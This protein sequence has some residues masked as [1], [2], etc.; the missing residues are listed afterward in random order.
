MSGKK[1]EFMKYSFRQNLYDNFLGYIF[2]ADI[3]GTLYQVSS[4]CGGILISP[5]HVLTA[6]HCTRHLEEYIGNFDTSLYSAYGDKNNQQVT[7]HMYIA[8]NFSLCRSM[9]KVKLQL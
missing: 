8:C 5:Y 7:F 9:F 3:K 2:H 1:G 6:R 4:S